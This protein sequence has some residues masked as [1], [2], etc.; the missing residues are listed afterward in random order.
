MN[1][2]RP[3]TKMSRTTRREPIPTRPATILIVNEEDQT[4]DFLSQVLAKEGYQVRTAR[5]AAEA[6]RIANHELVELTLLDLRLP[7]MD[8]LQTLQ[9]LKK[10]HEHLVV[11]VVTGSGT[12]ETARAAMM[13]GAFDFLTKPVDLDFLSHV[14]RE[15]LAEER[16]QLTNG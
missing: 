3:T 12:L 1:K 13:G 10:L 15:G 6:M 14:I 8:G 7:D 4:C 16:L 2:I 9:Q 5:S 11:I